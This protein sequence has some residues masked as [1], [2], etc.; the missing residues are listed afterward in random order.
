MDPHAVGA[1]YTGEVVKCSAWAAPDAFFNA[2]LVDHVATG[3]WSQIYLGKVEDGPAAG[4]FVAVKVRE[5]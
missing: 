1:D 3:G 2:V 5:R 4:A